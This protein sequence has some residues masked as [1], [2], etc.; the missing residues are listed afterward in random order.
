MLRLQTAA[1]G[2]GQRRLWCSDALCPNQFDG[3]VPR[4]WPREPAR[5]PTVGRK[6]FNNNWGDIVVR[7]AYRHGGKS[8][9]TRDTQLMWGL[10]ISSD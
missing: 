8:Q 1:I 2:T 7:L 4:T 3:A 5:A 6:A 10:A 9:F